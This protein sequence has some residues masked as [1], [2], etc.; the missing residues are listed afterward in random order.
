MSFPIDEAATSLSRF[1]LTFLPQGEYKARIERTMSAKT[2]EL[3]EKVQEKRWVDDERA[4][5]QIEGKIQKTKE[6]LR[7]QII[8]I[9]DRLGSFDSNFEEVCAGIVIFN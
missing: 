1:A 8:K 7:D 4:A 6:R 9:E 3:N 5:R 2:A